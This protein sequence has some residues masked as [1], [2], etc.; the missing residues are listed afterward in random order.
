MIVELIS[1]GTELLMGNII[2]TNAAYLSQKCAGLGLSLYTQTVVGDNEKR[3]RTA[4]ECALERSDIVILTGGLGP[5]KDDLTKEVVAS[6]LEKQLICDAR[7]KER[8]VSYFDGREDRQVI[9]E[10]NWKQADVIEG[11]RILDNDNGTAPGFIVE[12]EDDKHV[13]LMP[14]PPNEMNPM[15]DKYVVPYLLNLTSQVLYSEMVKV[16]GIG[17]SRAETMILD[18]IEKQ[19]NPTIAPYAKTSEVHFRITASGTSLEEAKKLVKPVVRELR[20]RF[21]DSIYTTN[22]Q[23]TLEEKVVSMLLERNMTITTAESLTGGLLAGKLVN[24]PGASA[25]FD[26]GLITYSNR[27]KQKQLHV[28][29]ETLKTYGAVSEQTAYEMAKGALEVTQ[30]DVSIAVTGLAGPDGGTDEKPIG[31]VYIGCC[32]DGNV[33]VEKYNFKGNRQKIRDNTVIMALDLVR[34]CIL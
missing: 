30:S 26:E 22:E 12:T 11:A 9:T 6:T 25:V 15:F 14:G 3:L 13:I 18:L 29:K 8:I 32:V 10:N 28:S 17:E 27:A 2:N 19:S 4:L 5:T 7:T 1:V 21:G 24:V 23:E 20:E 33:T 31:L 34:R 16:C